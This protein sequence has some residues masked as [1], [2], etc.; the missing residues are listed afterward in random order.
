S[1]NREPVVQRSQN[2][3]F[4]RMFTI[5]GSPIR[6]EFAVALLALRPNVSA[7]AAEAIV[8]AP[9]AW[10]LPADAAALVPTAKDFWPLAIALNPI[11]LASLAV[12]CAVLP[13]ATALA[14]V[15]FT[16]SPIPTLLLPFTLA[17]FPRAIA[18]FKANASLPTAILPVVEAEVL[19]PILIDPDVV[20][21]RLPLRSISPAIER[22]PTCVIDWLP[23]LIEPVIVPPASG[24]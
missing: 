10:A 17:A 12:A 20:I 14:P 16:L 3:E 7:S 6:S 24:K 13:I 23:M 4:A 22:L 11:E 5:D 19:L 1:L 15:I 9:N 8:S 18:L 21:I 2:E